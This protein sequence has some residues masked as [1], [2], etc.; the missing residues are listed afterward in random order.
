M[1]EKKVLMMVIS[2]AVMY[3]VYGRGN[4]VDKSKD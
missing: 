2:A 1:K 4:K 3:L